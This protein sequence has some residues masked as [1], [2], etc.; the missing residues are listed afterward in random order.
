MFFFISIHPDGCQLDFSGWGPSALQKYGKVVF[1]IGNFRVIVASVNIYQSVLCIKCGSL[2]SHSVTQCPS[3][4]SLEHFESLAN[5]PSSLGGASVALLVPGKRAVLN[6]VRIV[7][8]GAAEGAGV[9]AQ[10]GAQHSALGRLQDVRAV[11]LLR[12]AVVP[13]EHAHLGLRL[14]PLRVPAPR[15]EI[16]PREAAPVR[17][18]VL[19]RQRGVVLVGPEETF[20]QVVDGERGGARRRAAALAVTVTTVAAVSN[21]ARAHR[22]VV[23]TQRGFKRL[24]YRVGAAQRAHGLVFGHESRQTKII[25]PEIE[26]VAVRRLHVSAL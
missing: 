26:C 9:R 1:V 10:D 8:V 18:T 7:S 21:Y 16:Q 3:V 20:F 19:L 14:A 4:C 24:R 17:G 6:R 15:E 25:V 2:T 12:G 23:Q 11:N 22:R 5:S 13:T